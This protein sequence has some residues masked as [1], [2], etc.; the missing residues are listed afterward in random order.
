[1]KLLTTEEFAEQARKIEFIEENPAERFLFERELGKGA[2][3]KVFEAVE[4]RDKGK[5]PKQYACRIMKIKD[6]PTL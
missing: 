5:Q 6:P 4:R 3:C 1:M 2:M